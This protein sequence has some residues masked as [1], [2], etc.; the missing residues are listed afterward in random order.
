MPCWYSTTP[1]CTIKY[2]ICPGSLIQIYPAVQLA[3]LLKGVDDLPVGQLNPS[4][5]SRLV[6]HVEPE[7][8]SVIQDHLYHKTRADL[9]GSEKKKRGRPVEDCGVETSEGV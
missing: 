3:D 8:L 7:H 5:V 4:S 9:T 6:V 1:Y 2:E